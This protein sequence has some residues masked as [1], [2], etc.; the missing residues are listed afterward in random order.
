MKI[1]LCI[2]S[3]SF[4][5]LGTSGLSIGISSMQL[6]EVAGGGEEQT[7][8]I[9]YVPRAYH[10]LT[11]V[12]HFTP[13]HPTC[14]PNALRIHHMLLPP[15]TYGSAAALSDNSELPCPLL[16]TIHCLSLLIFHNFRKHY[17]VLIHNRILNGWFI[18][19]MCLCRDGGEKNGVAALC[20]TINECKILCI[21]LHYIIIIKLAKF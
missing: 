17:S 15:P 13:Y 20:R 21:I 11:C 7:R 4:G 6:R 10:V 18:I 5:V 9:K 2:Y 3:P 16:L 8:C 19:S 1:H 14:A 12:V